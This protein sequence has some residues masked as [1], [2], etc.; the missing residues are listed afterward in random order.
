MTVRTSVHEALERVDE[1]R[2]HVDGQLTAV[3]RFAKGVTDLEPASAAAS[4]PQR[5]TDGGVVT[6]TAVRRENAADRRERVRELFAETIRPYSVDDLEDDEPLVETIA[7]ELSHDVAA[8]LSPETNGAFTPRVKQAVLSATAD[9]RAELKAINIALERE[10]ESLESAAAEID[11]V[12]DW[13]CRADETPLL[14]LGFDD[15]RERHETLARHRERCRRVL[16]ERQ[17]TLRRTANH[18]ASAGIRQRTVVAFLYQ[19]FSTSHPAL[20]TA[21]RLE[22]VCADCQRAVRDHLTRRV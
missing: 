3:D 9:R 10:A 8:A 12:T 22:K 17:A 15:L 6:A 21:L 5:L 16:D 19:E 20:T 18:N 1:E 7:E 2:E 11:A 14:E 13:I 4:T